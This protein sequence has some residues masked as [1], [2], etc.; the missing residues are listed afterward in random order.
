MQKRL[1]FDQPRRDA[2]DGIQD[3]RLSEGK[4]ILRGSQRLGIGHQA[5]VTAP[6]FRQRRRSVSI[7]GPILALADPTAGPFRHY[8]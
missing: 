6:L 8:R 1:L 2:A 3:Y 5:Q 4:Q 7:D